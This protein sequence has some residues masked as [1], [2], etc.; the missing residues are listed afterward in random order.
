[1]QRRSF[2][3]RLASAG[4]LLPS[5]GSVPSMR[6]FAQSAIGSPLAPKL[7]ATGD[8]VM[9]I[10]RLFGG[11]DGL[12]TLVPYTDDRYYRARAAGTDH[13]L[14]IAPGDVLKIPGN[15]ALG[16]HPAFA[17]L[18]RLYE[19]GKMAIV[20]NVGYPNQDLSHFRSTD[21]WLSGS[22]ADVYR[23]SGWYARYL[24]DAH[25][26]FPDTLPSDPFAVEMG[27]Y[28]STSL[29]GEHG[30]MGIAI[31][32]LNFV[33][34]MADDGE[35]I[36][37][38]AG[39]EEG[40]IRET[41]RQSNTFLDAVATAYK[42]QRTNT[43]AYPQDSL[44]GLHLSTVARMIA[45]GL[46]TQLYVVN[47]D[48]FDTHFDQ[49]QRHAH[50][51]DYI[52]T[53]MAAFQRDLEGLGLAER[54]CMMTISEF[55]R[56]VESNGTG[57]DHGAAAPLFVIGH[58]VNGG[59][60]GKNPDLGD[61]DDAGN[62]RMVFDFRQIYASLLG[63]WFGVDDAAIAPGALPRRF[64]Q[65]P[66][67]RLAPSSVDGGDEAG[68]LKLGQS[69]PNPASTSAGIAVG[70]IP[71]GAT[72]ELLLHTIDGRRVLSR[73]VASWDRTII[74]D[75]RDLPAGSYL[76]TLRIGSLNR[77]RVMTVRR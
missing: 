60:I 20:Q 68:S 50:L 28:L 59:I 21:I 4:I 22:D 38:N 73:E 70:G 3:K 76:Y 48:G 27:T 66:I 41:L 58:G 9:V 10:I 44:I 61:L 15:G 64:D 19:E 40:F 63:G 33:P 71:P 69:Y 6:A 18:A 23:T 74:L 8:R 49:R 51:L 35:E 31:S 54:V 46:A 39:I 13:D 55:G 7:A 5:I 57:T 37:T 43:V 77:S 32:D 65:L 30:D 53:A 42:R 36:T 24:E 52:A 16:F 14:S 2:L 75:L 45:G 25:P 56:R 1:M 72:A 62:L 12:N 34:G 26:D 67:F 47:V 29:V 11:N 17:P